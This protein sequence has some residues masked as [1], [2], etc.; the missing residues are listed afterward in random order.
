MMSFQLS[1]RIFWVQDLKP[2]IER[3]GIKYCL[4]AVYLFF[5]LITAGDVVR[6]DIPVWVF[7]EHNISKNSH[8]II[9]A[10]LWIIGYLVFYSS[11]YIF[12]YPLIYYISYAIYD[13]RLNDDTLRQLKISV[14]F[15]CV[16]VQ[17]FFLLFLK[18]IIAFFQHWPDCNSWL[19]V[20][21]FVFGLFFLYAGGYSFIANVRK[22]QGADK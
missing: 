1:L 21:S 9:N 5:W 14:C 17:T 2:W 22:I 19:V 3:G 15:I 20:F 7:D 16:G 4:L 6:N 13:D 10:T 11:A 8:D 12:S 18:S